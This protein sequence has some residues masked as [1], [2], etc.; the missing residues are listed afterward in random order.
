[1][2]QTPIDGHASPGLI[3]GAETTQAISPPE[4]IQKILSGHQ[5]RPDRLLQ[6]LREV[7]DALDHVSDP[8]LQVIAQGLDISLAQARSTR[9][10]YSFLYAENRGRF[11]VLFSDNITDRMAG[12]RELASLMLN[13]LNLFPGQVSADGKVSVGFTS[14][15]G[16]CDQGPAL[17]INERAI[18]RLTPERI[19]R[20]CA[21]I[22][23][24]VALDA[25]PAELFRIEDNVQRADLLLGQTVLPGEALEAAV[26]RGRDGMFQEL[27]KANLRGR[28]GAGFM[29]AV[30]WAAARDSKGSARYIVCNADEG[31]PGTF[32]DRVLL[33]SHAHR[34]FEGMAIAAYVVGA[35]KGLLYLRAEY[36]FLF[37]TLQVTLQNMRDCNLLGQDICG[38]SGFDFDIEIHLGAGAY[39]CGEETALIES[40]EGK[41]GRPRI[42]PPFPVTCG[43]LNQPTV[44]NNVETLCKT[45]E[46]A[47][48]GGEAYFAIG[49]R[50]STGTK[51]LSV[52]GDCERPGVYEYAFGVRIAQV[53]EDCGACDVKAVQVSGAAGIC[54]SDREFGRRI[55]FED[56][57]TA[58][59]FMVFGNQRDMFDVAHNFTRFFAHESCGFCSPCRVGTRLMAGVMDKIASGRATQYEMNELVHLQGVMKGGCHCGLGQSAG[60]AVLD[61]LQKFRPSYESRLA[62]TDFV[63][64]VDLEQALMAA[65]AVSGQSVAP[66]CKEEAV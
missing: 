44:V 57:P 52:S 64:A 18:A 1:V 55:A 58:G 22:G 50:Q 8:T 41:A 10:F 40:L 25:W 56:V 51:L 66:T 27:R 37:A 31:E 34:V 48:H 16:M 4:L 47:L 53:L 60:N 30:K 36:R 61:T 9:D 20:I 65:R 6:I 17:L 43:Y 63:S 5:H 35:G 54:L 24:D 7:Q 12:N 59:S 38:I 23:K 28:G 2:F 19:T 11:R 14:C 29:T 26:R 32:K 45:T 3:T 42:R 33:Q 49:T 15:T 46:I 13:T 39:V 21:L 62:R